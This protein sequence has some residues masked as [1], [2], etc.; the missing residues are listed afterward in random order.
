MKTT[1]IVRLHRNLLNALY[2]ENH[3]RLDIGGTPESVNRIT[4]DWF[5]KCYPLFTS[6]PTWPVCGGDVSP[7]GVL[8]VVQEHFP[9]GAAARGR[10]V[11]PEEPPTSIELGVE[12]RLSIS[13]PRVR[14]ALRT[15]PPAMGKSLRR[16]LTM[17]IAW[18]L[19][20]AAV[21]PL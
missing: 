9:N 19:I 14:W 4:V 1:L 11:Y 7:E 20:A 16:Y 15:C 13:R 8:D 2:H 6:L 3:I 17:G 21:H 12:D 10:A 5:M 18:R